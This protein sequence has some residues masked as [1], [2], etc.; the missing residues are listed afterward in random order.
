MNNYIKYSLSE[1]RKYWGDVLDNEFELKKKTNKNS[2]KLKYAVN[3]LICSK[4]G[5]LSKDFDSLDYSSQLGQIRGCESKR[6]D[7]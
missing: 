7:K 2:N 4:S 6:L 5:K 3:F 1:K